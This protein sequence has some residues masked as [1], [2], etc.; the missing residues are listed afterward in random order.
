MAQ[1]YGERRFQTNAEGALCCEKY[2]AKSGIELAFTEKC[3]CMTR[4]ESD[5]SF[6]QRSVCVLAEHNRL[7]F[8]AV[9]AVCLAVGAI[10]LLTA[11]VTIALWRRRNRRHRQPRH[12]ELVALVAEARNLM[13]A[14]DN[15]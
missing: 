1:K 7:P 5:G 12:S 2:L 6:V 3:L 14:P 13:E 4:P 9:L 15:D 11:L 8:G 10:F